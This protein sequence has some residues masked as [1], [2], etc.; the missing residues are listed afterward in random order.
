MLSFLDRTFRTTSIHAVILIGLIVGIGLSRNF[1]QVS[2]QAVLML[3]LCLVLTTY[4]RNIIFVIVVFCTCL[5]VGVYRGQGHYHSLNPISDSYYRSV[6]VRGRVLNDGVYGNKM[7]L[8]FDLGALSLADGARVPGKIKVSGFGENT[9][10][11]GNIAQVDGKLMPGYG[12]YEGRMSFAKIKLL[13]RNSNMIEDFRRR[14]AAGMETALPEPQASFAMG[15]IVGQRSNLPE[16]LKTAFLMVGLTHIIA[17]SGYNLTIIINALQKFNTKASKRL[18]A[19]VIAILATLFVIV[20]GASASIVRA[21]LVSMLSLLAG[22]YGRS[23]K[24]LNLIFFVAA[25]TA[26]MNPRNIWSDISW[27][28]S[29]LAF[30]GVLVVSPMIV[31][32]LG[33]RVSASIV[34][35]AVVESIS[36]E[37]MCLP[38]LLLIFGQM[39]FIG[40]LA[41]ALVVPLVPMAMFLGFIAGAAAMFNLW[42][43]GWISLPAKFL[44]SFILTIVQNLAALPKIF[45]SDVYINTWTTIF[46]YTV[47]FT[48]SIK[49]LYR[50]RRAKYVIITDKNER[51][52]QMVDNQT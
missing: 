44:L 47:I 21:Y 10:L 7:Q 45:A 8:S 26:Y 33:E 50:H 29:F 5:G 20:A 15:I 36:A 40:L 41:N 52:Q 38:L 46:C 2:Y 49:M 16:T 32:A 6:T 23:F 11:A 18:V 24:P 51:S 42:L 25:L 1:G 14:F 17:V 39:S 12:Q 3:C 30:Y 31:R 13:E 48:I 4:K 27:Y 43:V 34:L 35:A 19:I 28:L 9:I 22:V 37:I